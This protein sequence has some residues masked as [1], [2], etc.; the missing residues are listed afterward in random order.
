M[1]SDNWHERNR[2]SLYTLTSEYSVHCVSKRVET[3]WT[4]EVSLVER[5]MHTRARPLKLGLCRVS[6]RS[7]WRPPCIYATA[8]MSSLSSRVDIRAA[9]ALHLNL[10]QEMSA[11]CCTTPTPPPTRAAQLRRQQRCRA[12]PGE[13][14]LETL[15]AARAGA[16]CAAAAVEAH[17]G[18][19]SAT[20]LDPPLVP[21]ALNSRITPSAR[22]SHSRPSPSPSQSPPLIPSPQIE[23]VGVP[24][25]PS[26][27]AYSA[28]STRR[29]QR[30]QQ[31]QQR[32]SHKTRLLTREVPIRAV[33][34]PVPV[35]IPSRRRRAH[36]HP[37]RRTQSARPK[38]MP[39]ARAICA[40][41]STAAT[42]SDCDSPHALSHICFAPLRAPPAKEAAAA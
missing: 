32:A 25:P 31:Q 4:S 3:L 13:T 10:A 26:P 9:T 20:N 35:P 1:R 30:R 37:L 16:L 17:D 29:T 36:P 34:V 7:N 11:R 14:A 33:R 18:R 28:H 21:H 15:V 8:C 6:S 23:L 42:C 19:R 24:S 41:P 22:A 39:C 40:P 12:A 27:S 5:A 2:I 38:S